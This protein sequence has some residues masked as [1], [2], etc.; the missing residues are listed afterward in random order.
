MAIG[1]PVG[2]RAL[3]EHLD[4]LAQVGVVVDARSRPV[5][6]AR[7]DRA[8]PAARTWPRPRRGTGCRS[9]PRS[10]AAAASAGRGRGRSSSASS[11]SRASDVADRLDGSG[12]AMSGDR[13]RTASSSSRSISSSH[14]WTRSRWS[15]SSMSSAAAISDRPAHR[16]AASS[17]RSTSAV[18]CEIGQG[19]SGERSAYGLISPLATH[20]R[21]ASG[22]PAQMAMASRVRTRYADGP[23]PVL[24]C[25]AQHQAET[26]EQVA[27]AGPRDVAEPQLLERLVMLGRLGERDDVLG[28][29]PGER[30]QVAGVAAQRVGHHG[31]H[32]EPARARLVGGELALGHTDQEHR[33]PLEALGPVD[34]EQLDRVGLGRSGDVEPLAELVLGLEPGQQR[35]ERHL[36]VDRL[37]LGD[38]LD[39]QVE[40]LPPG[41]RGRADRRG[42]LDV[43]AGGV[44]DPA[45]QVEDRLAD[46]P[47]AAD[48]ARRPAAR[49]GRAPRSSSRGRPGRRA[50]RTATGS[51]SGRRPRPPPPAGRWTSSKSLAPA[52]APGEV[53]GAPAEQ[54]EVARTDRPARAGQQREQ[55]GVGGDVL[56]QGEGGDDLGDLGQPEQTL[57]TDDLDGDLAVA[58]RVEDGGGVRVV[59]GEHAD[60]APARLV[61]ARLE[62]GVGG[63][64]LL[65]E[66][67]RARRRRSRGR[68]RGRRRARHRA[69]ARAAAARPEGVEV[70]ARGGWR[71]RGSAASERR[72][73]VSGYVVRGRP[74]RPG[75]PWRTR[76]CW[77]PTRLASRRSPGWGRRRRSPDGRGPASTVRA[78]E[79]PAQHQGLGDRGVLVLVEQHDLELVALDRA[80]LRAL[81]RRAGRP[82]RSG[83]RSPSGRGGA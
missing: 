58:Q 64:D 77:R 51:R 35:G 73:T 68:R 23:R 67:R 79:Q 43:D 69:W 25:G 27:G 76:G 29:V 37:E 2:E 80:D 66:P 46:A 70:G 48:A 63:E 20:S 42:Q 39:E 78:G 81:A 57:E 4:Q 45:H 55:R 56:D 9:G 65:G 14:C 8:G 16:A 6:A 17:R 32:G 15:T 49:T 13:S 54:G 47:T 82:A 24:R 7:R 60:L 40:V 38:R 33:V 50:R 59:A 52:L 30:R 34:G 18:W 19:R 12:T 22:S 11:R 72:L 44:D 61:G 5:R 83:R 53:T 1:H 28:R 41:G 3:L 75:S 71:S 74:P 21:Q 62:I 26:D 10:T 36:A 31:R